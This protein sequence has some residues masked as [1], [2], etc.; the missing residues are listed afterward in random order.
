MDSPM[1]I[2]NPSL[3]TLASIQAHAIFYHCDED[4][5]LVVEGVEFGPCWWMPYA[6]YDAAF[7]AALLLGLIPPESAERVRTFAMG[8]ENPS[9]SADWIL[10]RKDAL[11]A[12]LPCEVRFNH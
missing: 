8:P 6:S 3:R 5:L 11:C 12:L 4:I 9:L 10:C 1:C 7:A 2:A